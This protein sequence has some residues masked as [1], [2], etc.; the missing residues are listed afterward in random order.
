[1]IH[2]KT[3]SLCVLP[4]TTFSLLR[5]ISSIHSFALFLFLFSCNFF[6]SN[7]LNS[8]RA[9][10]I[11]FSDIFLLFAQLLSLLS[12][13]LIWWFVF[14]KRNERQFKWRAIKITFAVKAS[15]SA[16]HQLTDKRR[17]QTV[18]KWQRLWKIND[19]KSR[20]TQHYPCVQRMYIVYADVIQRVIATRIALR[21]L[22]KVTARNRTMFQ[23]V[24]Y[25][26]F[27]CSLY[28]LRLIMKISSSFCRVWV[29]MSLT[30][31]WV[32]HLWCTAG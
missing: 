7:L 13:A 21:S 15:P 30:Y 4:Q 11:I 20:W 6:S 10:T 28:G 22:H 27:I 12:C 16:A 8:I 26:H 32:R 19:T 29:C 23:T 9:R 3:I 24:E 5:F 1:M 14:I 17:Q 25:T 2:G 18:C 31:E